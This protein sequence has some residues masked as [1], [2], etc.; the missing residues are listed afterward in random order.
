MAGF[1]SKNNYFEFNTLVKQQI[2]ATAI[3]TKFEPEYSC[4]FLDDV[5]SKF[6]ETQLFQL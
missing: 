4:I 6:L 3:G 2:F 5:E 1:V